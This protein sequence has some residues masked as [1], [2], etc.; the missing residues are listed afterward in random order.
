MIP[1]EGALVRSNL[2]MLYNVLFK[3]I[4]LI[5]K[6]DLIETLKSGNNYIR[7]IATYLLKQ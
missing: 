2:Y 5:N 6:T 3:F 1:S 7:E 4:N